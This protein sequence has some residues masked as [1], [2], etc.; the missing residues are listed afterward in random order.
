MAFVATT[1][2]EIVAQVV[3]VAERL[4]DKYSN[5]EWWHFCMLKQN[6]NG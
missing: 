5:N 1:S 4:Y 3:A 6:I 2:M